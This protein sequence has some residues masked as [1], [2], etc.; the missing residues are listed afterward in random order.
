[1]P[2]TSKFLRDLRE[3]ADADLPTHPSDASTETADSLTGKLG[4]RP[5][6]KELDGST[7][8]ATTGKTIAIEETEPEDDMK[9]ES[10][11]SDLPTHSSAAKSTVPNKL[12]ESD[13]ED[14]DD[15]K[16]VAESDYADDA[17]TVA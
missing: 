13:D 4:A 17:K 5:V 1:M 2:I 8:P 12:S 7:Y 10:A 9:A 6:K 16:T 3:S 11:E 15:A 14:A